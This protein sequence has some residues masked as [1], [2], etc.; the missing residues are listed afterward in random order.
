MANKSTG[1]DRAESGTTGGDRG[2]GTERPEELDLDRGLDRDLDEE[3]E[4]GRNPRGEGRKTED[5]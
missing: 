3:V 5:L 1:P 4:Q 2:R